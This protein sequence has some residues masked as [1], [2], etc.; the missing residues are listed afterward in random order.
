MSS[1]QQSS[2]TSIGV[3]RVEELFV[4]VDDNL[5]EEIERN[6]KASEPPLDTTTKEA[7]DKNHFQAFKKPKRSK[8]WDDFLEPKLVNKQWKVRCKYCNQPLSILK[9]KSTS[10]LKRHIDGCIKKSR[11]LKQKQA[12]NFLLSESS[13]GTNQF[14][15]VSALHDGKIDILKMREAMAHWITMHEHPF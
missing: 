11:F 14:E 13:T 15:F 1:E 3:S 12:L 8:V 5:K 6:V 10:N 4:N 2:S 7:E 9:S